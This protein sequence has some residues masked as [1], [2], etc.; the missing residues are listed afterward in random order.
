MSVATMRLGKAPRKCGARIPPSGP[1]RPRGSSESGEGGHGRA[2]DVSGVVGC[3]GGR[4]EGVGSP[5][6]YIDIWSL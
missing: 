1:R 3:F 2:V 6:F 4:R 5:R